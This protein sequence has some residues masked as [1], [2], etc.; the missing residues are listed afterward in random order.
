MTF[1]TS[2]YPLAPLPGTSFDFLTHLEECIRA[3]ERC[4]SALNSGLT[5]LQP[6]VSDLPRLTKILS[7]KHVRSSHTQQILLSPSQ[8]THLPPQSTITFLLLYSA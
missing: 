2:T 6:G 8:L 5:R 7:N 3:T 1:R 4:S